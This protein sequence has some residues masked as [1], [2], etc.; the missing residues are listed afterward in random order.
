MSKHTF[1]HAVAYVLL[2]VGGIA[3]CTFLL[4]TA[5]D[6]GVRSAQTAEVL[7]SKPV[8]KVSSEQKHASSAPKQTSSAVPA[9]TQNPQEHCLVLVGPDNAFPSWYQPELTK[10]FGIQV[11]ESVVQPFTEMR[12]DASKDGISLWV[13][14]GY[15]SNSEQSTLFQ[16]E[17]EEYAKTSPTYSE[18]VAAAERSVAKPGY[19]EHATGLALDLN[20][21]EDDF[22]TKPAFRWLQNH[23][24]DYGFILRY[25]K[26]KQGITKIK[27]EP[28][29]FRYVG[30]AAAKAMKQSG[31]CFEEY[32]AGKTSTA[33]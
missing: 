5:Y 21:V 26:E 13:S 20:G 27:Y 11:D 30:I 33:R 31:Q 24:Q 32:M 23:A 25:P 6:A 8:Q 19:S 12:T 29:H 14:S 7:S 17:V 15:R 4:S 18:A 1:F 16:R 28:W 9:V 10:I 3:V 2:F 22:D